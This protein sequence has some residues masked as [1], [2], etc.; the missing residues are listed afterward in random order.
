MRYI[1]QK[2]EVSQVTCFSN[3]EFHILHSID[4]KLFHGQ[5]NMAH[6]QVINQNHNY[7]ATF[8]SGLVQIVYFRELVSAY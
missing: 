4:D 8:S 2:I 1:F 5:Y 7:V 3:L 6:V